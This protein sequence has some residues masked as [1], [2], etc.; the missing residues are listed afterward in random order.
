M[1]DFLIHSGNK[2]FS[3]HHNYPEGEDITGVFI[4][5]YPDDIL[6]R[7]NDKCK[8]VEFR[9]SKGAI[10][11]NTS[12]YIGV[13]WLIEKKKTIYI[14]PK[15]NK[16][17]N[18]QTNYLAMLFSALR[19]PE[20]EYKDVENLYEVKWNREYISINQQQDL[21]TP[22]LVVQFLSIVKEIVR[23][24]LKKSYYKIEQNLYSRVKGKVMVSTTIKQNA[25]KN[26]P[27]NTWCSFDEFGLNGLENRLIKKALVFVQRF[28][29]TYPHLKAE[30]YLEQTMGYI[31]PA[32]ESVS[33]EVNLHDIL[34][35]K[36]NAFYKEYKEGLRLAKLILKRFGYNITNTNTGTI[37]TPPFWINMSKLFELYVLGLLKDRFSED[38]TFQYSSFW[39]ELDFLLN[40]KNEGG[41]KMVIDAKYKPIYQ[42]EDKKDWDIANIRQIS[43]YARLKTVHKELYNTDNDEEA[44]MIDCLIIYPEPLSNPEDEIPTLPENLKSDSIGPFSRFYKVPVYLPVI[45]PMV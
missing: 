6:F 24:G 34:H 37:L 14:E 30:K 42:N 23:K 22:L 8:C 12:Y 31:M 41:Y 17:S 19:N 7:E 15:L 44:K 45:K 18:F 40:E 39:N 28:L 5:S 29:P 26:K 32:F 21:L 43:G 9:Y 13:D 10:H 11:L 33:E 38:V 1:S 16:E 20:I 35:T 4:D 2:H 25:F 3:E 27:L 36:T